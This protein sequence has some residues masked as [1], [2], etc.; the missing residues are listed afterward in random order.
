M[1]N[2]FQT[3]PINEVADLL[4]IQ[5]DQVEQYGRDKA[6]IRLEAIEQ[7]NQKRPSAN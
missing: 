1:S 6:K 3:K 2:A 4:G 7:A 5:T